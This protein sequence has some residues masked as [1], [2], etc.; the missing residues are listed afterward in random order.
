[1]E[2]INKQKPDYFQHDINARNDLQL[3][4]FMMDSKKM[5]LSP[6]E[7]YGLYFFILEI[8]REQN[9]C[10][11]KYKNVSINYI[12][13]QAG[14]ETEEI[15]LFIKT[16]MSD[17]YK[18]FVVEDENFFS[19]RLLNDARRYYEARQKY[20]EAGK[21]SGISRRKG[22]LKTNTPAKKET[23]KK[24]QAQRKLTFSSR[25]YS[26]WRDYCNEMGGNNDTRKEELRRI[27]QD[28]A[29]KETQVIARLF[30]AVN[31]R[32]CPNFMNN[33]YKG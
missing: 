8:L 9:G 30:A 6:I 12:A 16:A 22:S 5:N 1:M 21:Q 32:T 29:Q 7:A 14:M 3:S 17:D 11:M 33:L 10:K 31:G 27:E 19:P 20:V 2:Q 25:F 23:P 24:P 15:E 18:L 4:A 26:L 28:F 13:R